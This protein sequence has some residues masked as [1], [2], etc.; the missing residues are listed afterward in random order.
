LAGTGSG[1]I[2]ARAFEDLALRCAARP[3]QIAGRRARRDRLRAALLGQLAD[4][5]E[6][7][8]PGGVAHEIKQLG[9]VSL[10]RTFGE[11]KFGV[12]MRAHAVLR[13][14]RGKGGFRRVPLARIKAREDGAILVQLALVRQCSGTGARRGH[15][16]RQSLRCQR[17]RHQTQQPGNQAGQ[18]RC[19]S[20]VSLS[21]STQLFA[22][23]TG[24]RK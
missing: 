24:L 16:L 17:E 18:H 4:P 9:Q 22:L 8:Q 23:T 7:R 13:I 20:P 11:Q 19:H 6:L 21:S 3:E 2:V 10:W 15:L 14:E 12:Q 5:L 1:L